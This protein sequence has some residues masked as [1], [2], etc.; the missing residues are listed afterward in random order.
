[1]E[2]FFLLSFLKLKQTNDKQ[3]SLAAVLTNEGSTRSG[4][5]GERVA[6]T[7]LS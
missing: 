2:T 7:E 6:S 3:N 4:L 5:D 1:M